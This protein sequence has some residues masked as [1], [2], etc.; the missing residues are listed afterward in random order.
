MQVRHKQRL[1]EVLA[2]HSA[3]L[4]AAIVL[5]P[6]AV[7]CCRV[8]CRAVFAD[9]TFFGEALPARFHRR[10]LTDLQQADLL[11]VM[12]T[13]LLVQPFASMIGEWLS[14]V[15]PGLLSKHAPQARLGSIHCSGH[16]NSKYHTGMAASCLDGQGTYMRMQSLVLASPTT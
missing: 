8:P 9:I 6:S 7:M 3:N 5:M 16:K 11:I 15:A 10:R 12:G 13:S 2:W 4:L 14:C 1:M